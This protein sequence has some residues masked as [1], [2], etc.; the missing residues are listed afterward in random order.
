MGEERRKGEDKGWGE[1]GKENKRS[2]KYKAL[3]DCFLAPEQ[4]VTLGNIST[5][6]AEL[7]F[8]LSLLPSPP[9]RLSPT[10]RSNSWMWL[11]KEILKQHTV[12]WKAAGEKS[13]R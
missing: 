2:L 9:F 13:R 1:K 8:S 11:T 12:H 3:R 6:H 10:R 5:T 7:Q 4:N